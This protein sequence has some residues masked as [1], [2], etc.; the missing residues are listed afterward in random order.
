MSISILAIWPAASFSATMPSGSNAQPPTLISPD[1]AATFHDFNAPMG[2]EGRTRNYVGV[3]TG[4]NCSV[5]VARHIAS[6]FTA[7]VLSAYPNVDGVVAVTH[8][9]GCGPSLKLASNTALYRSECHNVV[10]SHGSY[11]NYC[12][13][14]HG[15][16]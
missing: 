6:H 1:K 2:W 11:R 14:E 12:A 5:T 3:F 8:G 9:T 4:V 16:V 13:R 7:E 15:R 10:H